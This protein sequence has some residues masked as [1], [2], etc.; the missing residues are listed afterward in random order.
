MISKENIIEKILDCSPWD[1]QL[2][3]DLMN[4]GFQEPSKTWKELTNLAKSANFEKLYPHF[5]SRLLDLSARSYNADL[6]L[7]SL[8]RF[9]E[10]F[11][12]KDHLFT[13]LSESESL[14]EAL[15]FLFSGILSPS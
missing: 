2:A 7:H 10:N 6:A 13:I 8:E 1:D 3:P 4:Y 12:D 5:F 14:L 11:S 15:I 9:S